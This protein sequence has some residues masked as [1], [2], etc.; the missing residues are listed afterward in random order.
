LFY[1]A[2][3]L[4][5]ATQLLTCPIELEFELRNDATDPILSVLG[6][7]VF[8]AANA[9][10]SWRIEHCMI[11]ASGAQIGNSLQIKFEEHILSAGGLNIPH[12][13]FIRNLQTITAA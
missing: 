10:T 11:K 5:C 13:T 7:S 9:S 4:I 8:T 6:A 3:W 12:L 1:T 2:I